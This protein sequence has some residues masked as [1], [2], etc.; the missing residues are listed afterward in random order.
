MADVFLSYARASGRSAKLVAGK[1]RSSGF[2]VWFDE[3]LPAHRTYSDVI[4]EQL[5]AAKAVV[6]LW[7][8]EAARSQWVRSEANRARETGRLV[9]VRLDDTRLPMPFDQIQCADLSNWSGSRRPA[10]W[11]AVED[12]VAALIGGEAALGA[13]KP[14]ASPGFDRRN[15]MI[16]G[17]A[18]AAVLALGGVVSLRRQRGGDASPEARLLLQKGLDALQQNDALDAELPPGAGA[19]AVALLTKATEADPESA[20][21]WGG[22]A[23]AYAVRERAS[24][25]AER[26]GFAERSRSAAE[27]AFSLDKRDLRALAALRMLDPVYR[28]WLAAE[29]AARDAVKLHPTFPIHIFLLSDVL[30]SVGRCREAAEVSNKAD[31]SR[32]LIPGADRKVMVNLWAA[33]YLQQAD[34]ALTQAIERWPEHPQIWRTRMAY[35]MFS[36]RAL[37]ALALIDSPERPGAIPPG[38]IAAAKAT[39][40]ALTGAIAASAAI[41]ANLHLARGTPGS[42]LQ[43]AQACAALGD[44][45]TAMALLRGYYFGKGDWAALAPPGGDSDRITGPLFLPPMKSLWR[46][47]QFDQLLQ[48]IGLH[49]YWRRSGTT[50]DFRRSS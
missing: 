37:E 18:A 17:G 23:M 16:A 20:T 4:E 36:G 11:R 49:E 44:G 25:P 45:S 30:G 28:N 8:A 19:Q 41:E 48:E 9:Q 38:L 10:A 31:R 3:D 29:R 33:G 12:S 13:V 43:V 5:E 22:L 15:V 50:P 47:P 24:P 2:S 35:L 26:A 6:V 42:A 27:R 7:S 46:Q 14:S 40:Q 21:A 1:L 39:G 32:F 34:E